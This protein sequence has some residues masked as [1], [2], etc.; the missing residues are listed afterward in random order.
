MIRRLSETVLLRPDDLKP[1]RDDF[2]VVGV[3]NPGAVKIHNEIVL[4]VRVAEMPLERRAGFVGLPRR[5][6]EGP[7]V[8]DWAREDALE[9]IDPRVVRRKSDGLERLT[10]ISHLRVFRSSETPS[11]NWVP[12]PLFFP[13][14]P[15]EE[16]GIEDPRVTEINGKYEI[17]YVA[18]S[19]YGA[20]TALASTEDWGT[21]ERHGL[22]YYPENKDVVLFPEQVQGQYVAFHRPNPNTHFSRPQ[23]W[24]AR[25]PDLLHWGQ[26]ECVLSGNADWE[27][28]RVGAGTPPIALSEGWLALYHGSRRCR[29]PGQ[30]GAYSAGAVLLERGNPA[31]ILR[32]T[33][34]PIMRPKADFER[35]G[36]VRNVVFPTALIDRGETLAMYYGAA[37]TFT[38]TVEFSR[39]ELLGALQ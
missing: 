27:S 21:F 36:F 4:L 12:G 33:H 32:R 10:S 5:S 6:L 7:I 25:S 38:A 11:S 39:K 20:G 15:T 26:H 9:W 35:C 1:S 14:D 34:M 3:F 23:I 30:V 22:I 37:D 24:L 19:R 31:R 28:D 16:Y 8:V 2:V 17:T 18:V 13:E 29:R